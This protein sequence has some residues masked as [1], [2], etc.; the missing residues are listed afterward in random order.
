VEISGDSLYFQVISRQGR[1][2]DSGKYSRQ[3]PPQKANVTAGK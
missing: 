3:A 2:I 1:T